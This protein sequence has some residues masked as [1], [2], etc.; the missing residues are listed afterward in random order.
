M[1]EILK[2]MVSQTP[3]LVGFLLLVWMFV[4][5]LEKRD[6]AFKAIHTEHIDERAQ[7]RMAIANNATATAANVRET[8][9]NTEALNHLTSVI[10]NTKSTV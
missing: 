8:L 10:T 4:R 7:C 3:A 2:S 6:D 9:R 1:I 5:H